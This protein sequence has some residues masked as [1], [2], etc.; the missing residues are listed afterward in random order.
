MQALPFRTSGCHSVPPGIR[1]PSSFFM[2]A[3]MRIT[4]FR[5][6]P[7]KNRNRLQC[8]EPKTTPALLPMQQLLQRRPQPRDLPGFMRS[9]YRNAQ[10]GRSAGNRRITD[11]GSQKALFQQGIRRSQGSIVLSHHNRENG[12]KRPSR[13]PQC[14]GQT[15]CQHGNTAAQFLSLP[16]ADHFHRRPGRR[17][18]KREAEPWNKSGTGR[19]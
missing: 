5:Q 1:Y 19:N 16:A 8:G 15:V 6:A 4:H 2:A 12:R 10:P 9:R 17:R 13:H 3:S 11:G 14:G 18:P 7:H